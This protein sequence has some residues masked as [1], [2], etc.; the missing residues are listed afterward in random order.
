MPT[1]SRPSAAATPRWPSAPGCPTRTTRTSGCATSPGQTRLWIEVGQPEDKPLAK[2]CGKA[3]EVH[4]YCFHHAAEVWWRG[5]ENKL[6]RLQNLSVFRVPTAR[7]AGAGCAGPAQHAVAGHGAGRRAD[8]RRRQGSQHPHRAAAL[9][10]R[11]TAE[12][13]FSAGMGRP[14]CQHSSKPPSTSSPQRHSQRRCGTCDRSRSRA[15][16]CGF[17]VVVDQPDFRQALVRR[18]FAGRRAQVI[19]LHGGRDA[20]LAQCIDPERGDRDVGSLG[21][22][23]HRRSAA[24]PAVERSARSA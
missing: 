4:V 12:V 1:G 6:S 10:V 17:L 13:P 21:Q 23:Q 19:A 9:E 24:G 5:I 11:R 2:A 7:I 22:P 16:A 14:Q 18:Q 20:G 3:D 8:A 15:R